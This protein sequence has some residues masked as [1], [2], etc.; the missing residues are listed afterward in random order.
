[1][2]PPPRGA[3]TAARPGQDFPSTDDNQKETA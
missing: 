3:G 1:M 2:R